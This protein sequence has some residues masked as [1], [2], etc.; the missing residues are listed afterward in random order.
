MT[1]GSASAIVIGPEVTAPPVITG[2]AVVN[3]TVSMDN[4]SWATNDGVLAYTYNWSDDDN[5]SLSTEADYTIQPGD[6]GQTLTA[7]VTA[8]DTSGFSEDSTTTMSSAVVD[9]DVVNTVAP[10]IT[11]SVTPG[12]E[13]SV[14]DGSWTAPGFVAITYSW[15]YTTGESGGPLNTPD[16]LNTHTVTADDFGVYLVALVT[17][18]SDGEQ[19]TARATTDTVVTPAAPFATDAG[20]TSENQGSITGNQT[21]TTATV[22]DPEGATGDVVFVY[23]YST[24][25]ALGFFTLDANKQISVPLS[26]FAKGSHKLLVINADGGIVGWFG[27]AATGDPTLPTTGVN[28]NVPLDLGVAGGLLLL[29]VLSVLYVRRRNRLNTGA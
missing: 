16:A 6:I 22:T 4:G 24:P 2:T 15:G 12:G 10:A 23:G 11:G 7:T 3:N 21:T 26:G 18:T 28:V 13:L 25:V 29:G 5:G 14:S 9:T 27:I 8:T 1:A 19:A 17:A 20:L